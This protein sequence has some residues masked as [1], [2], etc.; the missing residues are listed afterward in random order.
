M[1]NKNDDNDQWG[2]KVISTAARA[3]SIAKAEKNKVRERLKSENSG[4][5]A[6]SSPDYSRAVATLLYL[7]A[8]K[9]LSDFQLYKREVSAGKKSFTREGDTNNV[10]VML[11]QVRS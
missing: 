10:V 7:P 3:A 5:T 8:H 1:M 2:L 9:L 11:G 6:V 4:V